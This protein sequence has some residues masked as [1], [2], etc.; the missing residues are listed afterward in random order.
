MT[1]RHAGR[2]ATA[3]EEADLPAIRRRT[4]RTLL[5]TESLGSAGYYGGYA[6]ASVLAVDLLRGDALTGVPTSCAVLGA[7]LAS[8]PLSRRMLRVGRRPGLVLGYTVGVAGAAIVIAAAALRSFPLL[9]PGMVLF[10]I[11]N[12]SNHQARYVA[13]D[14]YPPERRGT[15]IGLIVWGSTVGAVLG[16]NLL[17]AS[18]TVA[19]SIGLPESSGFF[20]LAL[21]AFAVAAAVIGR[22]LRPDPLDVARHF[23]TAAAADGAPDEPARSPWRVPAVQV[24]IV[25]MTGSYAVMVMVMAMTPVH[26]RAHEHS[27]GPIGLVISAHLLGMFALS[28]LTGR[29][30]DRLGPITVIG[31]GAV[32]LPASAAVAALLDPS[33]H[34][35]MMGALFLLGL[36]WNF[37]FVGGSTLLTDALQ[38]GERVAMQGSADLA[39]GLT[40]A[41]ASSIAG[42]LY[43]VGGLGLVATAGAS[44]SALVLAVVL[45]RRNALDLATATVIID[46][47]PAARAAQRSGADSSRLP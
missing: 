39:T 3:F 27:L 6:A 44:I 26:L 47:D 21:G 23:D 16:P 1:A 24:A 45:G 28:P 11:A 4:V 35:P 20:L 46:D 22:S 30:C 18:G 10:G 7:A 34:E 8:V 19:G 43:A 36:G 14:V 5:V 12:T 38:G 2:E 17:A 13:G 37:G 42:V 40:S 31:F 32:L 15:A 25:A 33:H 41:A 9:L 29:L